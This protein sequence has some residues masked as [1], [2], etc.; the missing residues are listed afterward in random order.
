MKVCVSYVGNHQTVPIT[1]NAVSNQVDEIT[2]PVNACRPLSS[3][4][5]ALAPG[6]NGKDGGNTWASSMDFHLP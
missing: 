4:I 6:H 1:E 2:R 5:P 3:A